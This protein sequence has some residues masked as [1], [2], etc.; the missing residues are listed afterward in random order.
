MS[1]GKIKFLPI[2][3]LYDTDIYVILRVFMRY[4]CAK[5]K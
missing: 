5:C 2:R 4:K 3:L 1:V